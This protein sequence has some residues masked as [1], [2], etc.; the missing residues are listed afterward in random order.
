MEIGTASLFEVFET[1]HALHARNLELNAQLAKAGFVALSFKQINDRAAA[2]CALSAEYAEVTRE[3]SNMSIRLS[4]AGLFD[5]F[6]AYCMRLEDIRK[7][8]K[9]E[10]R[11]ARRNEAVLAFA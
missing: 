4:A 1:A 10:A 5:D 8:T 7:Q 2:G 6:C 3:A 9:D 11:K